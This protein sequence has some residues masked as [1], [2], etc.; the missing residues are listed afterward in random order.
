MWCCRHSQRWFDDCLTP[1]TKD[2][3]WLFS[4]LCGLHIALSSLCFC[5]CASLPPSLHI[6]LP[7]SSWCQPPVCVGPPRPILC[8]LA[9]CHV[10]C[11]SRA[12]VKEARR[13][14]GLLS[15]ASACAFV[16]VCD[17]QQGLSWNPSWEKW[18]PTASS[19]WKILVTRHQS[20]VFNY[21]KTSRHIKWIVGEKTVC[22]VLSGFWDR[23][24]LK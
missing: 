20:S 4:S 16:H 15:R 7:P 6:C 24:W 23:V 9:A 21:G 2:L 1:L 18:L 10:Q 3:T 11:V 19:Y 13:R 14:R 22:E 8:L 17:L 12:M 5:G